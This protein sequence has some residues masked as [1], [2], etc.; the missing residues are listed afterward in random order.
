MRSRA[1]AALAIVVLTV[2]PTAGCYQGFEGT[3]NTQGPTGN[4]VDFGLPAD[5]DLPAQT[6]LVQD[7]TIVAAAEGGRTA[8]V[9]F[10][11]IN[12]G[13]QPEALRALRVGTTNAT[14]RTAPITV[15]PGGA[16]QVG[17]PSEHQV[18]V[19]GLEVPAGSYAPLAME[20]QVAGTATAQ[21]PVVP[22]VGYYADWGPRAA[23]AELAGEAGPAP[24]AEATTE[25]N[26]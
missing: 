13:E 24:S 16:V 3:V 14:I 19:T 21:V 12:E 17:G 11:L 9:I 4:G 5:A 15:P 6:L 26:E 7:T 1:T 20:F 2:L 23:A 8:S 10:T 25:P 18:I 22:A